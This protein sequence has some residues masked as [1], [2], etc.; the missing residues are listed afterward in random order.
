MKMNRSHNNVP[1]GLPTTTAQVLHK[2]EHET[3]P[4]TKWVLREIIGNRIDNAL[5]ENEDE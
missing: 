4:V 1:I 2:L 5:K 3:N